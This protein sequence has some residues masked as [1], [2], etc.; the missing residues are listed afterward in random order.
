MDREFIK[1]YGWDS[2]IYYH[3]ENNGLEIVDSLSPPDLSYEFDIFLV[4]KDTASG[5]LYWVQDSGCSCPTPFED[6]R[7][8]SDL[9]RI[10]PNQFARFT[11][12]LAEWAKD[13]KGGSKVEFGRLSQ[14]L[15]TVKEA[16][17]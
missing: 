1:E 5:D 11:D 6:V 17:M 14:F 12:E 9:M 15:R 2:N 10:D 8:L 4:L 16:L 7:R 13:W 3:P